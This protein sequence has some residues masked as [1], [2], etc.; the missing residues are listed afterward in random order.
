MAAASLLVARPLVKAQCRLYSTESW[1]VKATAAK[2]YRVSGESTQHQGV[3]PDILFPT[4]VDDEQIGE[5]TLDDA[6][7]WDMSNPHRLRHTAAYHRIYKRCNY[8]M[9]NVRLTTLISN[10]TDR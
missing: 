1:A 7:P 6:M 2:F 10:T 9:I 3:T 4:L 5:S 8:A